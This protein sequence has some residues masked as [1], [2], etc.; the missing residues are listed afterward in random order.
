MLRYYFRLKRILFPL[1][2]YSNLELM[3]A[4]RRLGWSYSELAREFNCPRNSIEYL[5]QK[6]GLGGAKKPPLS[7]TRVKQST[8]YSES[9]KPKSYADYL[10]AEKD[11]KWKRLT[12][13]HLE[14]NTH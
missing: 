11:R 7:T 2:E 13:N 14:S 3:L 12:Q 4:L 10:Q 8:L 1:N 5:C 9:T 6:F